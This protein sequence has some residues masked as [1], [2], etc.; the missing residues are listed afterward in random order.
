MTWGFTAQRRADEFDA[1]VEGATSADRVRDAD[2]LELVGAMRS[3]PQVAPRP[4]FVADLRERLMAEAATALVPTDLARLTL[5]SRRPTRERR[6]AALVGGVAIVGATTS[7]AVASQSALPG[8]SLYPI[9]RA[10]ESAQTGLSVGEGS[11]GTT[12]LANASD[13]LTEV[14]ALTRQ[15][16]FG[17]DVRVADTLNAFTDQ[18]TEASDLLLAD[19]E[20]SGH[21]ASISALRDFAAASLD[22]LAAL[23]PF[24]PADARDELIRAAGILQTIDAEAAQHCPACGGTPI[25]SV[26]PTLT[27]A[28][29]ALDFPVTPAAD[30]QAGRRDK[31]PRATGKGAHGGEH[32]GD[33]NPGSGLPSVDPEDLGPGSVQNPGGG[34][35]PGTGAGTSN[36]L[37]DLTAGLTGGGS[38]TDAPATIP[39]PPSAGEVVAGVEGLLEG[40]VDP[41][42]GQTPKP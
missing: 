7:L 4:E 12:I 16:A 37:Q 25:D 30:S 33:T 38:G 40:V 35:P 1:M 18:V 20:H 14:D 17:D 34:L 11:K 5:P 2:L 19:Y 13:R 24:V 22:R 15:D 42:L 3:V 10:I 31:G 21:A 39:T 28:D 8:E 27:F 32:H 6:I 26:P 9:K 41:L 36:P 29:A 23:E